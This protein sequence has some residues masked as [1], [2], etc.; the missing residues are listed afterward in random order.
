M[1]GN[2]QDS[3]PLGCYCP[4]AVESYLTRMYIDARSKH[5]EI[6]RLLWPKFSNLWT[7][8]NLQQMWYVISN[9]CFIW[10]RIFVTSYMLP[11]HY[12][13]LFAKCQISSGPHGTFFLSEDVSNIDIGK[14]AVYM[15]VRSNLDINETNS[16]FAISKIDYDVVYQGGHQCE[17]GIE[18]GFIPKI[19]TVN[20]V[21]M[22]HVRL[23]YF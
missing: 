21:N 15:I 9:L 8:F 16:K 7:F 14:Y 23:T 12:L 6:T 18:L 20:V 13:H 2:I 5:T 10:M 1:E 4:M 17:W 3:C 19:N 22:A 11:R